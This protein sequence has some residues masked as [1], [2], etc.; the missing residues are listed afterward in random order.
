MPTPMVEPTEF[1][2]ALESSGAPSNEILEAC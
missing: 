1:Y 2:G